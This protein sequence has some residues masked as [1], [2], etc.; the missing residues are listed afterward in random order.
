MRYCTP[1]NTLGIAQ[2]VNPVHNSSII[3]EVEKE[4]KNKELVLS[5]AQNEAEKETKN[6]LFILIS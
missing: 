1:C 3:N 6:E 5:Q 4:T 2:D